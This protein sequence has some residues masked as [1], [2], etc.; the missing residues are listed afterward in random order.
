[1]G[2]WQLSQISIATLQLVLCGLQW[3]CAGGRVPPQDAAID[4]P[5][6]VDAAGPVLDPYE[7]FGRSL[8]LW[9]DADD[10]STVV[11]DGDGAV[12]RWRSK[13]AYAGGD[14][15]AIYPLLARNGVTIE[16]T[17]ANG[18]P[19]IHVGAQRGMLQGGFAG[20]GELVA[21]VAA[22]GN[23]PAKPGAIF[24]ISDVGFYI[25][26]NAM[27]KSIVMAGV[28]KGITYLGIW[29]PT[30]GWNDGRFHTFGLRTGLKV[31]GAAIR[32]DGVQ[33]VQQVP[34][35]VI[36]S[37]TAL[38]GGWHCVPSLSTWC[39]DAGV[40]PIEE[41]LEG[42]VAEVVMTYA[43]GTPTQIA[44]LSAYFQKKYGIPF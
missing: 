44:Q 1:M 22:Y 36:G 30:E 34:I 37:G 12:S 20:D 6:E 41:P 24:M 4:G 40:T 18:R 42:Y 13:G 35:G 16:P 10:A 29:T 28:M 2:R 31:G 19:A 25:R 38:I 14:V 15:V 26:G 32:A 43:S 7:I 8:S 21:V 23:E 33:W 3:S 11:R 39:G 27:G 5:D 17:V 9:L